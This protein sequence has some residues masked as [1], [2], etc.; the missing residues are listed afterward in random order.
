MW[1]SGDLGRSW[2]KVRDVTR[3]SS[4]N[5]AY[6]RRPVGARPDFWAFW[7]DGDPD[8]YSESRLHFCDRDGRVWRL[9]YDM[10]GDFAEP[11]PVGE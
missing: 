3:G 1:E 4:L 2:R 8:A 10:E 6:A 7:A 11:E 9:P 5:H